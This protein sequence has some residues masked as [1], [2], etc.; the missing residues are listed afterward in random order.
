MG[1]DIR[2]KFQIPGE[3]YVSSCRRPR[4]PGT[5]GRQS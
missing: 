4:M 3:Q 1:R 5:G 2:E